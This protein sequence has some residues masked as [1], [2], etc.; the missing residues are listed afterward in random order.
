MSTTDGTTLRCGWFHEECTRRPRGNRWDGRDTGDGSRLQSLH[1]AQESNRRVPGG[2]AVVMSVVF[3]RAR[4]APQRP[5]QDVLITAGR[6]AEV[7]DIEARTQVVEMIDLDGRML[8]PGLWDRH[9]HFDQWAQMRARLDLSDA[10]T[11]TSV[12]RLVAEHIAGHEQ[13]V[14]APVI[15]Y[16][17]RDALWPDPPTR[18][19]LDAVSGAIAVVLIGADLHS[20]WL[21][22]AALSRFG[23]ADNRTGLLRE[24][25]AMQVIGEVGRA[26]DDVSD[27]WCRAASRAAAA[28]GVVGIVDMERPW[29]LDA[30]RRRMAHGDRSFRVV[31][32]VWPERLDDAIARHLHTGDV[33]DATGGLL[34]VG[35]LKVIADGSL[36]TRTASCH[37]AYSGSAGSDDQFGVLLVPLDELSRIMSRATDA[38][39]ESAVHAIGD[40]ANAVAL[41]AFARTGA[42]GSIEHAQLLEDPD[43]ARF[44]PLGVVASVQPE[45]A[46]DDRDVADRYWAGRTR[47]AFPLRSLLD[48]GAVLSFGSDA[49]VAPLDPWLAIG[50][51][52]RRT[53]DERPRWHPEQE[54]TVAEALAA[55]MVRGRGGSTLRVGDSA[56]LI[57]LADDPF[58]AEPRALRTMPVAATMVDGEWTHRTGI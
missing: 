6:V 11:A 47:R 30:W 43:L 42:H 33:I 27:A 20:A 40:R 21:N 26:A 58:T 36:N 5:L 10:D 8:L 23:H 38:G 19:V 46:L 31:S 17:F 14:E 50:A 1:R 3:R 2:A 44:A 51:A 41:Q 52:V 37:D 4:I 53:R 18:E 7:G 24:E 9:V 49:P 34:S 55:S 48:A 13:P 35:P 29:S 57:V 39:L 16:G 28:R 25:A 56:D 22:S 54:I 45:H 32:S 12:A 15:G